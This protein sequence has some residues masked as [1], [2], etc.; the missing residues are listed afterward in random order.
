[1]V[2]SSFLAALLFERISCSA[3]HT[4]RPAN[5][6]KFASA[7]VPRT[8]LMKICCKL[9]K[10]ANIYLASDDLYLFNGTFRRFVRCDFIS[11]LLDVDFFSSRFFNI[12]DEERQW[13][14]AFSLHTWSWILKNST[15][16]YNIAYRPYTT[17]E[18]SQWKDLFVT[19]NWIHFI[20]FLA[21]AIAPFIYILTGMIVI[22]VT[23]SQTTN[24]W[25]TT[26]WMYSYHTLI[27]P[28]WR[29]DDHAISK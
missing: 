18:K 26:V 20:V 25:L 7:D 1:M 13:R 14:N 10:F 15:K 12:V 27:S 21:V 28:P 24:L 8:H 2:K 4:Q 29:S 17:M 23:V 6:V 16:L 22:F 5:S 3:G 11:I 19:S 9:I